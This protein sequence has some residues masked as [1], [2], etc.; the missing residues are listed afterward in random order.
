MGFRETLPTT[1]GPCKVILSNVSASVVNLSEAK[2]LDRQP[3]RFLAPAGL[4]LTLSRFSTLHRPRLMLPKTAPSRA[5][6]FTVPYRREIQAREQHWSA[7]APALLRG[8]P[9]SL[10]LHTLVRAIPYP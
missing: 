10:E 6:R 1:Q 5:H 4:G 7:P 2:D 8:Q 3:W 9:R